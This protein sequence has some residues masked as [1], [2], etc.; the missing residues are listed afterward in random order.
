MPICI[1]VDIYINYVY[2][3]YEIKKYTGE[4]IS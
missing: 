3:T 4:K 2:V 1:K